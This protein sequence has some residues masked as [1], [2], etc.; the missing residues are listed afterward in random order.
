MA[1][2]GCLRRWY[3]TCIYSGAER[4]SSSAEP[5]GCTVLHC[6][7]YILWRSL[8][9]CGSPPLLILLSVKAARRRM[10]ASCLTASMWVAALQYKENYLVTEGCI[11]R[12]K[13]PVQCERKN[14][15][16]RKSQWI[17]VSGV[18]WKWCIVSLT[19]TYYF[20]RMFIEIKF[21][22]IFVYTSINVDCT[23]N[24]RNS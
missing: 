6:T 11:F 4:L 17:F 3:L 12:I 5:P 15:K 16:K 7:V 10:R 13:I 9:S 8:W 1:S 22:F 20:Q 2:K 24:L 23:S 18:K 14:W 19:I 21:I